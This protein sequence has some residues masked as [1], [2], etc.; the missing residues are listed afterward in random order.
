MTRKNK[1]RALSGLLAVFA[2]GMGIAALRPLFRA[3][4]VFMERRKN[5]KITESNTF[6]TVDIAMYD[7]KDRKINISAEQISKNKNESTDLKRMT[8]DFSLEN[9]EKCK[10]TADTAQTLSEKRIDFKG[11]VRLHTGSGLSLETER[12]LVDLNRKTACGK[13]HVVIKKANAEVSGDD[14]F[15][16]LGKR[17][18]TIKNNAKAKNSNENIESNQLA[19]HL[20]S[21]NK[22]D[23][24]DASGC[25][26]YDSAEHNITAAKM[27]LQ[28]D[29][30]TL[31]GNV[32]IF[33]KEKNEHVYGDNAVIRM[34]DGKK[35]ASA[36]LAGN[37]KYVSPEKILQAKKIIYKDDVIAARENVV[38]DYKKNGQKYKIISASLTANL[39]K[40]KISQIKTDDKLTIKTNNST[41]RANRG[42]MRNGKL[43]LYGDVS[44][45]SDAG[46]ML[47]DEAE[48]D[49][50]A[51]DIDIRNSSGIVEEGQ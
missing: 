26:K 21:D 20:N 44:A 38:L 28:G 33:E 15:I 35:A 34:G 16:D 9:G 37:A 3:A 50:A 40:G 39:S 47:G 25:V 13:P 30:V 42:V 32:H 5:Q 27:H 24:A 51:G 45:S 41:I 4:K 43:F 23:C 17:T 8:S 2:V 1:I 36:D 11:N 31:S 14:Y 29:T 10:V 6:E 22:I 48:L 19:A 46:D 12:S 49:L 18:L 7:S